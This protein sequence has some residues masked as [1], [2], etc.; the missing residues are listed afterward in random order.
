MDRS[1]KRQNPGAGG[2]A[3]DSVANDEPSQTLINQGG[4]SEPTNAPQAGGGGG[5]GGSIDSDPP[6]RIVEF[7]SENLKDLEAVDERVFHVRSTSRPSSFDWT[8]KGDGADLRKVSLYKV[9]GTNA[10]RSDYESLGYE[11][12][13]PQRSAGMGDGS[14]SGD[15]GIDDSCFYAPTRTGVEIDFVCL[16][17]DSRL[18]GQVLTVGVQFIPLDLDE[19]DGDD[20][21]AVTSSNSWAPYFGIFTSRDPEAEAALSDRIVN[22]FGSLAATGNELPGDPS[23]SSDDTI[24]PSAEPTLV[25]D[26]KASGSSGAALSNGAIAGIAV[27]GFIFL[28]LIGLLVWFLLRR[29]RKNKNKLLPGGGVRND[30]SHATQD[31]SNVYMADKAAD[32]VVI[33]EHSP[34]SPYSDDGQF[35]HAPLAR[36]RAPHHDAGHHQH[37]QEQEQPQP[38]RSHADDTDGV[39]QREGAASRN[40]Q[41]L[42]EEGMTAED[43]RRLEEE[44]RQLDAEIERAAGRRSR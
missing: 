9:T 10:D 5:G 21:D 31:A 6:E 30:L 34:H 32:D 44:E 41:H 8:V 12:S 36:G 13:F 20:A 35:Q 28:S 42:V 17:A 39:T 11:R 15:G 2:T 40:Y 38:R 37:Q 3:G 43:I 33:G 27:G 25:S 7:A 26:R 19:E 24:V 1:R 29:R 16:G 23:D 18:L 14:G 22:D 4:M